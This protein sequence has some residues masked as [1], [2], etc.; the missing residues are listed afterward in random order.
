MVKEG[1]S[2]LVEGS[3]PMAGTEGEAG[4]E[5]NPMSGAEEEALVEDTNAREAESEAT[6]TTTTTEILPPQAEV[7]P[8]AQSNVKEVLP[9]E[10][11]VPADGTMGEETVVHS[12]AGLARTSGLVLAATLLFALVPALAL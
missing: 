10:D 2:N 1:A 7:D 6:T 4:S 5:S 12:G 9:V 3:S 11:T 8:S